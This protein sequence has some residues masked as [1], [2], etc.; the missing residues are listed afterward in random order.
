MYNETLAFAFSAGHRILMANLAGIT[1]EE[2]LS[3]AGGAA[4]SINW[5]AG[6]ILNSRSRMAKRIAAGGEP[7]LNEQ[8]SAW[9][10]KGSRPI[11]PGDPCV[12]LERIVK[13]LEQ[14]VGAVAT[15]LAEMSDAELETLVDRSM[16]PIPPDKPTLGAAVQFGILHEMYHSGQI[17]LVRRALG[18]ASGIGV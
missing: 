15:R 17:G 14:T 5:L 7:L 1:Q 10:G 11:G 13:G 18:K 16:F 4:N 8:E 6:H 3:S 2:S 12:P 9:Y